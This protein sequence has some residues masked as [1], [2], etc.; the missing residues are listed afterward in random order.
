MAV[1]ENATEGKEEREGRRQASKSESARAEGFPG[2]PVLKI[3][4][5]K[6]STEFKQRENDGGR[7][8]EFFVT[9]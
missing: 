1:C 8:R 4:I 5:A 3:A 9:A 6:W 7:R 2:I